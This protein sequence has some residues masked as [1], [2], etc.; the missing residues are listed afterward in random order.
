VVRLGAMGDVLH[1]LP[2][3]STLKASFPES[4]ITWIIDPKWAILLEGNPAVDHVIR[5]DR[6]NVASIRAAW[7]ELRGSREHDASIDFQGLIKSAILPWIAKG[8]ATRFGFDPALLREKQAAWF[9][10]RP[11]LAT[12]AH[13]VDRNLELVTSRNAVNAPRVDMAAPLPSGKPEGCLPAQPFVLA[14]PFAGWTSKQWPLERF[15][16]LARLLAPVPLVVNGAPSAEAELRRI[17]GAIPHLSGI[18]GLIDAT[19]R[20]T[21]VVGVD[22]GPLHLAATLGKPG[23]AIFGPTDPARN[24]PYGGTIE[25]LRD[26][27]AKTTYKRGSTID[28]SMEAVSSASVY[29]ALRK[30]I[31][32]DSNS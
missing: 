12:S 8:C 22:S 10:T 11:Y 21:A 9:Y 19:R 15:S 31:A 13:V 17:K 32:G 25:V 16:E 26:A 28:P 5:F 7:R 27:S 14:S 18:E 2:A 3:V 4:E 23:V 20:A 29:A 1:A 30:H 6:R 24:G